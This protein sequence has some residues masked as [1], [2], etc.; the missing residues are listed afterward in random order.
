MMSQTVT[1][2]GRIAQQAAPLHNDLSAIIDATA[3]INTTAAAVAQQ[4][5]AAEG[6]VNTTYKTLAAI[7]AGLVSVHNTVLSIGTQTGNIAATLNSAATEVQHIVGS[8]Q[9]TNRYL[10]NVGV[11]LSPFPAISF[12]SAGPW[13]T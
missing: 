11:C 4:I 5:V 13:R 1:I 12:G 3:G 9:S 7:N 8:A 2:T 6:S 10:A